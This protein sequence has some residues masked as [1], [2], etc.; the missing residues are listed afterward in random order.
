MEKLFDFYLKFAGKKKN[1]L[2]IKNE[3]SDKFNAILSGRLLLK[4]L[5]F[6]NNNNRYCITK[7]VKNSV[8]FFPE[9]VAV[10]NKM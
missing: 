2:Y 10:K 9:V 7:R 3:I 1:T 4:L 6:N 5:S 8:R